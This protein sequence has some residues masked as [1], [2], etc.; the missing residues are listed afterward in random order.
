MELLNNNLDIHIPIILDAQPGQTIT[1]TYSRLVHTAAHYPEM[2]IVTLT[3]VEHKAH[4]YIDPNIDY[5]EDYLVVSGQ[6]NEGVSCGRLVQGDLVLDLKP[7]AVLGG[8]AQ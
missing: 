6:G 2:I 1:V 3:P 8:C 5:F 4:V 7:G